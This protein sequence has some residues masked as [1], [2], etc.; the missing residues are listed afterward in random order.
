ML[1]SSSGS[2]GTA[3]GRALAALA[4]LWLAGCGTGTTAP[5]EGDPGS[6][7]VGSGSGGAA[8]TGSGGARAQGAGSGGVSPAGVGGQL[9]DLP[10]LG[11]GGARSLGLGGAVSVL[12][13]GR[14]VLLEAPDPTLMTVDPASTE[15]D[16]IVRLEAGWTFTGLELL[17]HQD[18][19]WALARQGEQAVLL[20]FGEME[21]QGPV[22]QI[23]VP[24]EFVQGRTLVLGEEALLSCSKEDCWLIDGVELNLRATL[25]LGNL[26]WLER[27]G[28]TVCAGNGERLY[29]QRGDGV[30]SQPLLWQAE[31]AT[32]GRLADV[33]NCAVFEDSQLCL[34]DS[35]AWEEVPLAVGPPPPPTCETLWHAGAFELTSGNLVEACAPTDGSTPPVAETRTLCRTSTNVEKVTADAYF[36]TCTCF[37]VG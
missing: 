21:C 18:H 11:S 32:R 31:T 23:T 36:S 20:V 33:G 25:P 15:E 12:L 6:G 19:V 1:S 10:Q 2:Q 17:A 22:G 26:T 14:E 9:S 34:Q 30:L 8:S 37:Y 3:L 4:L 16:G 28:A 13:G 27:S 5:V 24:D 29:C 35:G 7:G